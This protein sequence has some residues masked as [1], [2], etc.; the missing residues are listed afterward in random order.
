M[1]SSRPPRPAAAPA[2]LG[3]ARA[4]ARA[5]PLSILLICAR[6]AASKIGLRNRGA[7]SPSTPASTGDA[8]VVGPRAARPSSAPWFGEQTPSLAPLLL[9]AMAC[10]TPQTDRW[11]M[12]QSMDAEALDEPSLLLPRAGGV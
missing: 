12:E 2:V 7:G 3:P 4:S 5:T 1:P 8:V 10:L 9:K 11:P 6:A